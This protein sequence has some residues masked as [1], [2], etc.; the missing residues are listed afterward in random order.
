MPQSSTSLIIRTEVDVKEGSI[1]IEDFLNSTD[2]FVV[3]GRQNFT[4]TNHSRIFVLT[5]HK[6]GTT[7]LG[8]AFR[9]MGFLPGYPYP[10]SYY[11][12]MIYKCIANSTEHPSSSEFV[13]TM[14]EYV[15]H[16]KHSKVKPDAP[17]YFE[18]SPWNHGNCFKHIQSQ[19][20]NSLFVLTVRE[21]GSWIKSFKT[22]TTSTMKGSFRAPCYQCVLRT[23]YGSFET[24]LGNNIISLNESQWISNRLQRDQHI[25]N[26]FSG[27]SS[28]PGGLLQYR[29][30]C[31]NY[32]GPPFTTASTL[33]LTKTLGW[34]PFAFLNFPVPRNK[35]FPVKNVQPK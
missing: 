7:A 9:M 2:D 6:S 13:K 31:S 15:S 19:Y 29:R 32:D 35:S 23:N 24:D 22:W 34:E 28:S 5:P 21:T 14:Q 30:A 8:L 26:F 10:S 4:L 1:Q 18:D 33:L 17:I 27:L 3:I 16:P 12:S 11:G 25:V 20:P